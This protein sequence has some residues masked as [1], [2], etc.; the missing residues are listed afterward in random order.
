MEKFQL[1]KDRLLQEIDDLQAIQ[2]EN[3]RAF[4]DIVR[5]YETLSAKKAAPIITKMTNDEALK[6]LTNIKAE[7]LAGILEN[8]QPEDAAKYT[9]LLTNVSKENIDNP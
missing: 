7:T 3:K 9:Q 4:K 6:I 2:A 5:T 1:E 8:M